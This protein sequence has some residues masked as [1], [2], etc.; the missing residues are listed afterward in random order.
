MAGSLAQDPHGSLGIYDLVISPTISPIPKPKLYTRLDLAAVRHYA[1]AVN[2]SGMVF[3]VGENCFS[4]CFAVGAET[5][6][7]G[8]KL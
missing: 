5:I 7:F 8:A 1:T 4:G 6:Q 2:F 3:V